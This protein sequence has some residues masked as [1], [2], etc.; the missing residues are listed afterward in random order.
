M[1]LPI[2][3]LNFKTIK[4]SIPNTI[5]GGEKKN[6]KPKKKIHKYIYNPIGW[7]F[8]GKWSRNELN[9]ANTHYWPGTQTGKD[10]VEQ[11]VELESI[12]GE[13]RDILW[14]K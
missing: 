5:Q 7:T 10:N 4:N 3:K 14:V 11:D 13:Y 6:T 2:L 12:K 8:K 1:E 9:P